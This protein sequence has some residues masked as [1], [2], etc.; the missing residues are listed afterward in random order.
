MSPGLA[1]A[2]YDAGVRAQAAKSVMDCGEGLPEV[3][4]KTGTRSSHC[5]R[6]TSNFFHNTADGRVQYG[7]GCAPSS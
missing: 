4:V 3:W 5:R 2:V 7:S 6:K 1:K